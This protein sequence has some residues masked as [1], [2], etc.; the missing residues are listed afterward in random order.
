MIKIERLKQGKVAIAGKL[1]HRVFGDNLVS[2]KGLVGF[3]NDGR[4]R[5]RGKGPEFF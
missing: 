5:K 1:S 4:N 3:G 2:A